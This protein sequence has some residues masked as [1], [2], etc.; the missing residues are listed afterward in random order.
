MMESYTFLTERE[1]NVTDKKN[2]RV[3]T[4]SRFADRDPNPSR[5]EYEGKLTT[6]QWRCW[7]L[8]HINVMY[9]Y[10]LRGRAEKFVAYL[11]KAKS[12]QMHT[13]VMI[14]NAFLLNFVYCILYNWSTMFRK[15]SLLPVT[16]DGDCAAHLL[17]GTPAPSPEDESRAGFR[18]LCFIC[19]LQRGRSRKEVFRN[20]IPCSRP[21]VN[22]EHSE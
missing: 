13:L 18:P 14:R 9:Y 21:W 20:V 15:P 4:N 2:V 17:P 19:T 22:T 11:F 7:N 3:R 1:T 12:K 5:L 6:R 16:G 10:A 8:N